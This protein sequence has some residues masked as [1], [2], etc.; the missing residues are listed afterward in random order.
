MSTWHNNVP[1]SCVSNY[2][3]ENG[4]ESNKLYELKNIVGLGRNYLHVHRAQ[5]RNLLPKT[6]SIKIDMEC[7]VVRSVAC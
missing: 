2:I 4:C 6:K 5:I 3:C 7:S 1:I